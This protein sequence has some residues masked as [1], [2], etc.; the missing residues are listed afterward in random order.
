MILDKNCTILDKIS[1][2]QFI[3]HF[4]YLNLVYFRLFYLGHRYHYRGG[5]LMRE[6]E[7]L[8]QLMIQYTSLLFRIAYY[9]TKNLHTAEDVVQDVFIKFFQKNI[10]LEEGEIQPYLIRMTANKAKDY[11]KSCH[12]RKIILQEKLLFQRTIT[13]KDKL[14]QQ[15][16][17]AEI[18]KAILA[19]PLKQREVI[20]YYY[21]EGLKNKEI[22]HLLQI[23]E[24]T[25]KSRLSKGRDQLKEQL[26]SI[27]WEV[28][29]HESV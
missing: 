27:E 28:L 24:S 26:K 8:D 5:R 23:P 21:L 29:L 25:V 13:E 7:T 12:Y 14:V 1:I 11:L 3:N 9:Y 2:R 10:Q 17:E 6:K 16:E 20:A 15:D 19:L 4:I 22:A 18:S